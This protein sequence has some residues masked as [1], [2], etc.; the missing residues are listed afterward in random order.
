MKEA[1]EW[2]ERWLSPA[3]FAPYLR[4]CG[5]DRVRALELYLRNSEL[6]GA[7]LVDLGHVEIAMRNAYDV[8]LS[9]H[10][11]AE[12]HWTVHFR[13]SQS[14]PKQEQARSSATRFTHE[15][16]MVDPKASMADC[17]AKRVSPVSGLS[18]GFWVSLT[19]KAHE[20]SLWVPALRFAYPPGT[21][22]WEVHLI[23]E[24]L[25]K[26]RNR[27]AHH[28][29]LLTTDVRGHH[30]DLVKLAGMLDR[31]I[32]AGIFD[33]SLAAVLLHAE[34]GQRPGI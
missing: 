17:S 31:D 30:A 5:G 12:P 15:D 8:A 11:G 22:R 7:L 26:L 29:S 14:A 32:A 25:R 34:G 27:V 19:A 28:E 3:R 1:G 4:A 33:Q 10:F 18:F 9:R 2:V 23:A 6:A 24:R 16:E 13:D 20:R 21:S